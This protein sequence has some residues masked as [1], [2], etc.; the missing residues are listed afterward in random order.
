VGSQDLIQDA[1]T[2]SYK[3][4]AGLPPCKTQEDFTPLLVE[5]GFVIYGRTYVI[6]GQHKTSRN[7]FFCLEQVRTGTRHDI[8]EDDLKRELE[9]G[10]IVVVSDMVVIARAAQ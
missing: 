10:R 7:W 3:Q 2:A 1:W 8:Q 6:V 5:G 4:A 9:S